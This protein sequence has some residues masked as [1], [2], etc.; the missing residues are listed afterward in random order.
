MATSFSVLLLAFVLFAS[1]ALGVA[2][3]WG[4]FAWTR[5]RW[6]WVLTPVFAIFWFLVGTTPFI[7]L[8]M[9]SRTVVVPAPPPAPQTL[10][11]EGE[12]VTEPPEEAP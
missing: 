12:L 2:T 10:D 5:R 7:L 11:P 8:A 9:P 6:V 1:I 4:I 3:A